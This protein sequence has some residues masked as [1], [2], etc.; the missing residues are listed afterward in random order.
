M[1][2]TYQ[3]AVRN[4]TKG[5]V[6]TITATPRSMAL[7]TLEERGELLDDIHAQATRYHFVEE[8]TRFTL[9]RALEKFDS[10]LQ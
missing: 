1:S 10:Q 6:A 8:L 2:S 7:D 9:Q 5:Q 3:G 4:P